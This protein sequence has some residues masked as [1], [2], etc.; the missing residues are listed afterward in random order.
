MAITCPNTNSQD[1][2]DLVKIHGESLA[3]YLWN[4]YSGFVPSEL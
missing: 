1:W 4:R 2:K 3:A